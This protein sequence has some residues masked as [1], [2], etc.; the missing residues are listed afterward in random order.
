MS[1]R[2]LLDEA[3]ARGGY[4]D[5]YAMLRTML[6]AAGFTCLEAN[7]NSHIWEEAWELDTQHLVRPIRFDIAHFAPWRHQES[8]DGEYRW[9]IEV[10]WHDTEFHLIIKTGISILGAMERVLRQLVEEIDDDARR[11]FKRA[12]AAMDASPLKDPMEQTTAAHRVDEAVLS[13]P[14][15]EH[16]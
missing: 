1:I 6:E 13:T 4:T 2:R 15:N 11:E 14:H 16:P 12:L 9:R 10:R 5:G 3:L 7:T 8:G